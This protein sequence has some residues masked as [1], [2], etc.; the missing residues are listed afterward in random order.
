MECSNRIHHYYRRVAGSCALQR[1]H[2]LLKDRGKLA[3][4]CDERRPQLPIHQGVS[5]GLLDHSVM[6]YMLYITYIW[7]YYTHIHE[8]GRERNPISASRA[9]DLDR[10]LYHVAYS[11]INLLC[12]RR[13]YALR[14]WGTGSGRGFN[15][16]AAVHFTTTAAAALT[17]WCLACVLNLG[18]PFIMD[19]SI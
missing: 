5:F 7:R 2:G 15:P 19:T 1:A 12:E 9:A 17:K 18:Q 10:S 11:I 6:F 4:V 16:P 13:A 14:E 8:I 3:A